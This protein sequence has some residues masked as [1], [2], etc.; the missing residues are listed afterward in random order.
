M[1]EVNEI[2]VRLT[3]ALIA[4]GQVKPQRK[5]PEAQDIAAEAHKVFAA[6]V[7]RLETPR[8]GE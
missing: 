1:K 4:A 6:L 8:E 2:A 7:Q 3:V 5:L